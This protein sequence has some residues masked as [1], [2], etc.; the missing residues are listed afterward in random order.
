MPTNTLAT[1]PEEV[2]FEQAATL[3][4]VGLTAD[5]GPYDLVL[6]S[7]GGK[8]LVGILAMPAAG[9]TC[10]SFGVSDAPETTSH[11]RSFYLTGDASLYGFILFHEFLARPASAG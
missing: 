10:V 3:R 8:V 2:S 5:H 9:G 1:L 11:V 6:E 7:V 4:V